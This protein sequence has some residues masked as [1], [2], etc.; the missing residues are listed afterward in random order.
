MRPLSSI[1]Q[2]RRSDV[3][4]KHLVAEILNGFYEPGE[5]L[6]READ[7]MVQF[8]ISRSVYREALRV[9]AAKGL[10]E[11]HPKTGTRVNE[12]RQWQVL[13]RDLL[14]CMSDT[15]ASPCF[16]QDLIEFRMTVAPAAAGF[17]AQ[18]R[19]DDDVAGMRAALDILSEKTQATEAGRRAEAKFHGAIFLAT[20]N[21]LLATLSSSIELAVQLQAKSGAAYDGRQTDTGA[22]L[23]QIL[24]AIAA[25]DPGKAHWYMEFELREILARIRRR[26]QA[27]APSERK[28]ARYA[29]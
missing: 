2:G 18:R 26:L 3:L 16:L 23:N 10:I 25:R 28:L 19:T 12:R 14:H 29:G 7:A 17:A 24:D 20:K 1:L 11:S 21:E 22:T 15:I 9:V 13:D 8:S 6:P 4:A 5:R 27:D